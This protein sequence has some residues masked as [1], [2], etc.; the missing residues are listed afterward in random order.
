MIDILA[1]NG[2][3]KWDDLPVWRKRPILSMPSA[4]AQGFVKWSSSSLAWIIFLAPGRAK[5]ADLLLAAA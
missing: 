3:S 4:A 1:E 2:N 5:L